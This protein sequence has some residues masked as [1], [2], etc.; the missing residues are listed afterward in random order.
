MTNKAMIITPHGHNVAI[1]PPYE[2]KPG[3]T[4]TPGFLI[5]YE[6][7]QFKAAS[8]ISWVQAASPGSVVITGSEPPDK[9]DSTVR[10]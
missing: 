8:V 2:K 7:I 5:I 6:K 9:S 3:M 4:D 1:R 10:R